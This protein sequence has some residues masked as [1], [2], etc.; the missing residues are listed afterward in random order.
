MKARVQ[1][2]VDFR[3]PATVL[4]YILQ[5]ILHDPGVR[6][7]NSWSVAATSEAIPYTKPDCMES[8]SIMTMKLRQLQ[9]RTNPVCRSAFSKCKSTCFWPSVCAAQLAAADVALLPIH[10]L[11]CLML[12]AVREHIPGN[13]ASPPEATPAEFPE[14]RSAEG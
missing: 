1:W 10:V 14:L 9:Y 13:A 2:W 4:V 3:G 12:P 7:S 6:F 11:R 8:M 5:K